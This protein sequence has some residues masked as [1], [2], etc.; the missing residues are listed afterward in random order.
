MKQIALLNSKRPR[1][2]MMRKISKLASI[3]L[4]FQMLMLSGLYQSVWAAMIS[5]E[6]IIHVDR[7]QSPRDYINNLLARKEI[8]AALISQGIDPQEA[9]DRIDNLSD[10]EIAKFV[11]EIDQM[12]AGGGGSAGVI[13]LF[14]IFLFLVVIDIFYNN[15]TTEN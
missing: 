7:G 2:K 11:H 6:S 12:P 10:D 8:Q 1:L 5:T 4:A 15:S 13:T 14:I 3:F 9:R